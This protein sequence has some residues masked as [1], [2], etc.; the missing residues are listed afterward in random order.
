M[1]KSTSETLELF[2]GFARG[3][4]YAAERSSAKSVKSANA[5]GDAARKLG[6]SIWS[7]VSSLSEEDAIAVRAIAGAAMRAKTRAEKAEQRAIKLQAAIDEVTDL[8]RT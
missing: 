6:G 7:H 1:N 8:L 5:L 3:R 2:R 4:K